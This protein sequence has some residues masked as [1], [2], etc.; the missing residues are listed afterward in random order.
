MDRLYWPLLAG[1]SF[2]VI[3]TIATEIPDREAQAI[4]LLRNAGLSDV[5]LTGYAPFGCSEDDV[6][7][8]RFRAQGAGPAPVEGVVCSGFL[9]GS[10]IHYF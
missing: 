4:Q 1:F 7:R 6:F 10:T 2:L 3:F 8:I 9:K 5:S